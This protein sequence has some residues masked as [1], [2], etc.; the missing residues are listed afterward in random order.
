[1]KNFVFEIGMNQLMI[2]YFCSQ[3]CSLILYSS[4][5]PSHHFEILLITLCCWDSCLLGYL[6]IYNIML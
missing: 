6:C 1:M 2:S 3:S 4:W 5:D